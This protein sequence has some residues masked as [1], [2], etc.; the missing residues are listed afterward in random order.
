[1]RIIQKI[2]AMYGKVN[3]IIGQLLKV[4]IFCTLS[5][6]HGIFCLKVLFTNSLLNAQELKCK[7]TFE[8]LH[9]MW[10]LDT[11]FFFNH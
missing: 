5:M 2:Q 1:M 10:L 9:Q 11:L 7:Y 8:F 4:Y 6:L 3:D